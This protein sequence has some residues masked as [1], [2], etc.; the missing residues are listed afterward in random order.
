[1]NK[2]QKINS[3]I[4]DNTEGLKTGVLGLG[5]MGEMYKYVKQNFESEVAGNSYPVM[6]SYTSKVEKAT[7]ENDVSASMPKFTGGLLQINKR[8]SPVGCSANNTISSAPSQSL[9]HMTGK[10]SYS[11]TIPTTTLKDKFTLL[12]YGQ[13]VDPGYFFLVKK[14]DDYI[15]SLNMAVCGKDVCAL[16]EDLSKVPNF[17]LNMDCDASNDRLAYMKIS[18]LGSDYAYFDGEKI[19]YS[20]DELPLELGADTQ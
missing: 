9:Y 16:K 18:I 6:I 11:N 17:E 10:L 5:Y 14:K 4:V 12:I 7:A 8:I 2:I 15:K 19:Q 20:I 3:Y 1:V 13:Y